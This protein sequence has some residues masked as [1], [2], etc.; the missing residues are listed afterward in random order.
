MAQTY[1]TTYPYQINC[2]TL[3]VRTKFVFAPQRLGPHW[4]STGGQEVKIKV[5]GRIE[6]RER[7]ILQERKLEKRGPQRR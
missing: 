5:K 4:K 6:R 7:K 1:H 3:Y 2:T